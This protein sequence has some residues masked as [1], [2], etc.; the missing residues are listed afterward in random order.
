MH[1]ADAIQ[2]NSDFSNPRFLEPPDSSNQIKNHFPPLTGMVSPQ[3]NTVIL[4]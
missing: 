4:P 3:S 1:Y 2:W